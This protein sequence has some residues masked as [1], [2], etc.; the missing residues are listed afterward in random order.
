MRTSALCCI[1]ILLHYVRYFYRLYNRCHCVSFD[2]QSAKGVGRNFSRGGLPSPFSIS[3]G[4]GSNTIFVASIVKMNEFFGRA[5]PPCQCLPTP[6]QSAQGL[7]LLR[8]CKILSVVSGKIINY[9][10]FGV[11]CVLG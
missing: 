7:I 5:P 1:S 3:R 2:N 11:L 10:E 8:I 6:L 4:G 9:H